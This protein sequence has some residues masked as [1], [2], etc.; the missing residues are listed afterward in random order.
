MTLF[1]NMCAYL[2]D[3]FSL[4]S[5]KLNGQDLVLFTSVPL[6]TGRVPGT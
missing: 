1:V 4:E 3:D 6:V 5:N 2:L